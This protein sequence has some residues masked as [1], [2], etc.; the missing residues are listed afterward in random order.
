MFP[1]H[2]RRGEDDPGH[3]RGAPAHQGALRGADHAGLPVRRHLVPVGRPLAR[4]PRGLAQPQPGGR[5]QDGGVRPTFQG[6]IYILN[7]FQAVLKY[8]ILI[9]L[10]THDTLLKT[11]ENL[12][13][14][15]QIKHGAEQ[16]Q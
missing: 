12:D 8:H 1:S 11:H 13:L 7:L 14:R 5:G 16:E 9:C 3:H 10:S 4:A 15:S 6:I 2:Q